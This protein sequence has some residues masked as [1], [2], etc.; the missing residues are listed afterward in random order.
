MN[1]VKK[2]LDHIESL[3]GSKKLSHFLLILLKDIIWVFTYFIPFNII[4]IFQDAWHQIV[5][6]VCNFFNR[7]RDK[8]STYYKISF[9]IT[10]MNRLGHLQKTLRKNIKHNLDYPNV[11]F[12]LLDYNS[13]DDLQNWI[14]KNFKEE[15]SSGTLVY[16]QTKKPENFHMSN[17]KN[18]AH[19][20]ASGEIVCNLD[21]DNFT[22]KDFAFYINLMMQKSLDLI[23]FRKH[24]FR[25]INAH[26]AGCGGR[27]FLS[28]AN[29]LKLGGY[30]E[31]FIGWGHEDLEFKRR[32][33][34]LG[35][36]TNDI[37][38]SFLGVIN[39]GNNLRIKNMKV[40]IKEAEKKNMVLL[41]E[42]RASDNYYVKNEPI[43]FT[44]IKRIK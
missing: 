11:E 18:I 26:I 21:A 20:L 39:H 40:S 13:A 27:V 44:E 5:I 33:A 25:Y 23:G 24:N 9:C 4:K 3:R 36:V 38:H 22:G 31:N 6:F 8:V 16:Y 19:N 10:C 1:F 43:D 28:K 17:A 41:D 42:A 32:A 2:N 14:F 37:P 15:L 7:Y 29:F 34:V 12:I 35:L 30:N